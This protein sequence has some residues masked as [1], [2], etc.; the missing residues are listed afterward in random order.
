MKTLMS[1]S[2]NK[3]FYK[4]FVLRML[5]RRWLDLQ[6]YIRKVLEP[7]RKREKMHDRVRICP[8]PANNPARAAEQLSWDEACSAANERLMKEGLK[9]EEGEEAV[10]PNVRLQAI[11]TTAIGAF[12]QIID[13]R[14]LCFFKRHSS[15]SVVL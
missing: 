4:P 3:V 14:H 12:A 2:C 1:V 6:E 13:Q 10:S 9:V 8:M 15:V 7:A 5:T 11:M